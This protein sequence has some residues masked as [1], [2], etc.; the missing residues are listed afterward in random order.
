MKYIKTEERMEQD[1]IK[2]HRNNMMVL[3]NSHIKKP[4]ILKG[5]YTRLHEN[6]NRLA[7]DK[8]HF[9]KN[10]EEICY[11][12]NINGIILSKKIIFEFTKE[13]NKNYVCKL[14]KN[15][16]RNSMFKCDVELVAK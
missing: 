13:K 7:I 8:F 2:E 3:I 9:L 15:I 1:S 14:A 16:E 11:I 4:F 10:N 12:N 6:W 5:V